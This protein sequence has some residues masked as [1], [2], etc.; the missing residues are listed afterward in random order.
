MLST[1]WAMLLLV[2]A[3]LVVAKSSPSLPLGGPGG[4]GT[5]NAS[6]FVPTARHIACGTTHPFVDGEGMWWESDMPFVTRGRAVKLS[7]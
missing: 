1:I 5:A 3:T 7:T 2:L 4:L 6:S